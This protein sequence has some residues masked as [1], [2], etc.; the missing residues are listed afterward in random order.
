MAVS[1]G[2]SWADSTFNPWIGCTPISDGCDRCYAETLMDKRMGR[3]KWGAGE[4]RDLTGPDTWRLPRRWARKGYREC[5]D[6]G[7]RQEVADTCKTC[8]GELQS[9]RRRVF[10]ASLS[11]VFD[12]EV[13]PAWRT[14]VLDLVEAT[15]ELDW[16]I[17]TKRVGNVTKMLGDRKLPDNALLGITVVNQL[18]ADRDIPKLLHLDVPRRFLSMEPLLGPVKLCPCWLRPGCGMSAPDGESTMRCMVCPN[19]PMSCANAARTLDWVIVGGETGTGARSM[20]L[21]WAETIVRRCQEA[22]VPVHVKQLGASPRD[23]AGGQVS[24]QH[25]KG[26]D[27]A[28]WPGYLAVQQFYAP[29]EADMST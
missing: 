13:D 27:P 25:P 20:R 19:E 12:N 18:E 17:L 15:P 21:D 22:G 2:I 5:Q 14:R 29:L 28:E 16:M 8:G 24:T 10:C 23:R 9:V 1:T 6:C 3:V 26:G 7:K 4:P 11:D